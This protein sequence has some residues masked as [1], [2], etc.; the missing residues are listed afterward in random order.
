VFIFKKIITTGRMLMMIKMLLPA[1]KYF[2]LVCCVT[3]LTSGQCD[4]TVAYYESRNSLLYDYGKTLNS[5]GHLSFDAQKD[6]LK[7]IQ[8]IV[9]VPRP[10]EEVLT[11]F[12]SQAKARISE[13]AEQLGLYENL[14]KKA[15]YQLAF[16]RFLMSEFRAFIRDRYIEDYVG[17]LALQLREYKKYLW[18]LDAD[19][20]AVSWR[21]E[22][23][24]YH[25]LYDLFEATVRKK[26]RFAQA[27]KA[28]PVMFYFLDQDGRL[29]RNYYE[30]V[31][32]FVGELLHSWDEKTTSS[33]CAVM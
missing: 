6:I 9:T 11:A 17:C 22:A 32:R 33:S 25:I 30:E 28:V 20:I 1:L 31:Y 23:R 12:T 2:G 7:S 3:L 10:S 5:A 27:P 8:Q 29:M 18:Q 4:A 19:F 21:Y 14:Y 15:F 16:E 13:P 24:P 26:F